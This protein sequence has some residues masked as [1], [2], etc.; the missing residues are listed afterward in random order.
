GPGASVAMALL[1]AGLAAGLPPLGPAPRL[2]LLAGF[3][4]AA[5]AGLLFLF[6]RPVVED[7]LA[8]VR[9]ARAAAAQAL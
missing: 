8:L 5:Y 3:G 6:A 9:P 2:F 1:V 4:A 7:A